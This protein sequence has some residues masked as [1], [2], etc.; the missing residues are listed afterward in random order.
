MSFSPDLFWFVSFSNLLAKWFQSWP[1][2]VFSKLLIVPSLYLA[3]FD[4]SWGLALSW[5]CFWIG[6]FFFLFDETTDLLL[7]GMTSFGLGHLARSVETL[8]YCQHPWNAHLALFSVGACIPITYLVGQQIEGARL[9][10]ASQFYAATLALGSYSCLVCGNAW[11]VLG[12]ACFI[13]SDIWLIVSLDHPLI[14][15]RWDGVVVMA[16]YIMALK[17]GEPRLLPKATP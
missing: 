10:R 5:L 13:F 11:S 4:P 3:Q 12:M 2:I 8:S 14:S 9:R 17:L 15:P 16:T 7:V 1:L 6:D